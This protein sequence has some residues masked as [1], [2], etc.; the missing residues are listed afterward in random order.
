M[1]AVELFD[2]A[3]GLVVNEV[4]LRPHNSGHWTIEGATTSQFENHLR[5]VLDLPLGATDARRAVPSATVNVFGAADGAGLD[6]ALAAALRGA[7]RQGA[8][9]RQGARGPAGSWA[10]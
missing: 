7:D 8:P 2:T 9:L 4:A 5:A 1:L 3:D 10:T 6:G